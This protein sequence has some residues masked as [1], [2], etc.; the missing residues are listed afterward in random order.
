MEGRSVSH[1][2]V[3]MSHVMLPH[4]ANP[5]G[6]VHGGE[7]IKRMD[8]AAGIVAVRHCHANVVT[9]R[10]DGINFFR[11]IMVG[12]L[13]TVNAYLTFVS[14]STMDVRV[15]VVAED[16]FKEERHQSLTAHF[17]MVAVDDKGKPVEIPPLIISSDQEKRLWDYSEKRYKSCK[18]DLMSGDDE[19]KVCREEA[20]F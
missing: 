4:Q 10:V 6:A 20:L 9:A 15:E 1:S 2:Q 14:R 13:I 12:N 18:G 8:E 3:V 17:I 16:I 5:F 19:Y 7:I 11:P